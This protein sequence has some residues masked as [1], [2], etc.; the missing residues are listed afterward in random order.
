MPSRSVPSLKYAT[1]REVV[2][3][4]A[5]SYHQASL[6]QKTLLLDT[7]VAVTGYACKYAIG[8]LNR[9]PEGKRTIQRRRMPR[10]GPEVQQALL[11]AWKAAR[12]ICARR[13]IPYLPTL[14]AALERHGHL[15]LSQQSRSHLLA[16]SVTTAERCLRTCRKPAPGGLASRRLDPCSKNRSPFA[17]SSSGMRPSQ[18][19]W[20][21][22]WWAIMV[23]TRRDAFYTP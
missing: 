12:H 11:E 3:R 23:G 21:E 17:R 16:M 7:V 10:Y 8:L 4:I 14:V 9:V 15:Q 1:R 13:L 6:A 18:D 5:L 19:F 22:T 2:E 20:K